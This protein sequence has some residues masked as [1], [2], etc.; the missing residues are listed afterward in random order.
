MKFRSTFKHLRIFIGMILV[1][2]LGA[3]VEGIL[4]HENLLVA[5]G[6]C[7]PAYLCTVRLMRSITVTDTGMMFTGI[8]KRWSAD[9]QD[10]EYI[11]RVCDYSWPLDR[12]GAHTYVIRFAHGRRIVSF[13]FFPGDCLKEIKQRTKQRA[14][15]GR[16][17]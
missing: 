2:S 9:W 6:A 16:K 8:V 5:I 17:R 11:K 3:M 13:M 12:W 14:R 7:I 10:I 1:I 15:S 4:A